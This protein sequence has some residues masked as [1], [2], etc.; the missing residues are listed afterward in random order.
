MTLSPETINKFVEQ[1]ALRSQTLSTGGKL[2]HVYGKLYDYFHGSRGWR[3]ATRF[4]VQE[5]RLT[6]PIAGVEKRLE[7]VS[8]YEMAPALQSLILVEMK[9]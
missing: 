8:G 9:V 5:T 2:I 3:L 1:H 4:R 6:N 7:Y